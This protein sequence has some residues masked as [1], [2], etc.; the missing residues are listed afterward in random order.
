M[1]IE[2]LER[3]IQHKKELVKK[4]AHRAGLEH[5]FTIMLA[6]LAERDHT[7]DT[8][9]DKTYKCLMNYLNTPMDEDE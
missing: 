9:F 8:E 3:S 1:T 2:E 6:R 4:M 5:P 7:W